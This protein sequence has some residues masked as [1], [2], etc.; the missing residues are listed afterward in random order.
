[1]IAKGELEN[2]KRLKP[3]VEP[4]I[5]EWIVVFPPDDKAIK[6]AQKNGIKTFVK[7]FTQPIEP[8][9]YEQFADYGVTVDKNYRLFNFANARNF[10][11]SK[12]TGDFILW[13]DADD[14]VEGLENLKSALQKS[15]ADMFEVLYDYARDNEGNP[16]SDHV[17]ERIIRNNGKFEWKGAE[18]GLIHET[19]V[20]TGK[21]SAKSIAVSPEIF[22][23]VHQ[24]DHAD[25]SSER[26][27]I[28]LLYEYIKT[29]GKDP[30]TV[31]YLG[32]EFFNRKMYPEAIQIMQEYIK[33]GG[34]DEERY[35]AWVRIAESYHQIGDKESSRNAFLAGIKEM[36]HYL[37]AYL[38]LGESYFSDKEWGKAI[39]FMKT[40]LSKPLPNTKSGV[41][42]TRYT[43]RPCTYIAL[44]YLNSDN[45]VEAYNWF[46]RAKKLNPKHPWINEYTTLFQEAKDLDDY[47]RSFV[48]TAQLAKKYY[49]KTLHSLSEAVPEE[50]QDQELLLDFRRR[51]TKPK[52]WSDKSIVY[53]CSSAFED[54]GPDSLK[55]GCGGSEEAVIHLTRR[56]A[57][58]GYEVTVFNNCPREKTV[59]GV[60]WV[61]WEKFNPRDIFN[62]LI[63]WRNNPFVEPKVASKKFIDVHDVPNLAYFNPKTLEDVTLMVKSQYH[64]SLFPDLPDENFQI[65]NNGV[66]LD[67]FQN[68]V[69]TPNNLVYTSSYDRGLEYLLEMWA[70][71]KKEVPDATLD[72]AYGWNMFDK[73]SSA[74]TKE[75][76]AWK[77]KMNALLDQ[78]GI[79][80][81]G[82]LNSEE[83]T[84]LYLQAD[85]WA[86]PTDFPEIDCI[87]ATKAMAAKCVP[88]TTDYAVMKERNQGVIVSGDF[89]EQLIALLKDD[90]RKNELRNKIDVS[91]FDW[92]SVAKRWAESFES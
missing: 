54:W 1:M 7:D 64:R 44:A 69:K 21:A 27:F 87:S 51:F 71:V 39:E 48:K 12:A 57:K 80:H 60:Q 90:K 42:I 25:Q 28:A 43:F 24:S 61:R 46:N 89:K 4:H 41:D 92:D 6:W 36:P 18:L 49:P 38:G 65:I 30:R 29:N 34:W 81:H 8:K 75:G 62:I 63:S 66:E 47:V 35:R 79:T 88:I 50:L 85:V 10:S 22:T 40:G 53:F 15:E 59:D 73:S 67:K 45:T 68:P 55:T 11:F 32:T 70:D 52:I 13:L 58:M 19:L 16:I 82:R 56:W 2:L 20:P 31:Y 26:N 72:V 91:N 5:D 9:I 86:Y 17:R 74:K 37:D 84:K 78:D 83:V 3:I 33:V 23:V 77:A 76:Q 14:T